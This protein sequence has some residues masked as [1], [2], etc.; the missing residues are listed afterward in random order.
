[1]QVARN[2]IYPFDPQIN[3][4]TISYAI[5]DNILHFFNTGA[6]LPPGYSRHLQ[7]HK[8]VFAHDFNDDISTRIHAIAKRAARDDIRGTGR[9]TWA[10]WSSTAQ[11]R[12]AL[13]QA[14]VP[15]V[16]DDSA[17]VPV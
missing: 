1:M 10:S 2:I 3:L 5:L 16:G 11:N 17:A 6:L 4:E 13:V 15:H 8:E 12:P 9:R 7:S 14:G